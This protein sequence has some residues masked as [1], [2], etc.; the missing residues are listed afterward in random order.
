LFFAGD[1]L[2][3]FAIVVVVPEIVDDELHGRVVCRCANL[4]GLVR[5]LKGRD[6][7]VEVSLDNEHQPI[8]CLAVY[9]RHWDCLF[10]RFGQAAQ[11]A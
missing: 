7:F 5:E 1:D 3:I 10:E 8:T 11:H 9:G 2:V 6:P 4:F